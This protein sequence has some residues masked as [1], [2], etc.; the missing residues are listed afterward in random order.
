MQ[1]KSCTM[2]DIL[3]TG[4]SSER[5]FFNFNDSCVWVIETKLIL[6]HPHHLRNPVIHSCFNFFPQDIP[7][8]GWYSKPQSS[9]DKIANRSNGRSVQTTTNSRVTE[10][11]WWL[12][13]N[14][15]ISENLL[16]SFGTDASR[17][18]APNFYNVKCNMTWLSNPSW[19]MKGS[20]RNPVSDNKNLAVGELC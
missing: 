9:F 18:P 12:L 13:Y 5:W 16:Q 17:K 8:P 15:I 6:I 7:G 3:R 2:Y 10:V 14:A 4:F 1:L 11:R 20:E 19:S